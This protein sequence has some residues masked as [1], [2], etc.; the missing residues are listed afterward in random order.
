[1]TFEM[2]IVD[3][4]WF[5][6]I[7]VGVQTA[8]IQKEDGTLAGVQSETEDKSKKPLNGAGS[9]SRCVFDISLYMYIYIYIYIY[10]YKYKYI[11]IYI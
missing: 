11:N 4:G 10:I 6:G 2:M 9:F 1:M 3:D 7:R 5:N 8:P